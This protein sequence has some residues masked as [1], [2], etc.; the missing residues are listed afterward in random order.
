MIIMVNRYTPPPPLYR[1]LK[2]GDVV[3]QIFFLFFSSSLPSWKI[4]RNSMIYRY[5]KAFYSVCMVG[6]SN[7]AVCF[8]CI[9]L[10]Y[11]C[12]NIV[13]NVYSKYR[14]DYVRG[15]IIQTKMWFY[16]TTI[17]RGG[18]QAFDYTLDYTQKVHRITLFGLNSVIIGCFWQLSMWFIVSYD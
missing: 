16:H 9:L 7:S 15:Y 3:P 13:N 1:T 8:T 6:V 12:V 11:R 4:A 5:L 18:T 14:K 2:S 17:H 10:I